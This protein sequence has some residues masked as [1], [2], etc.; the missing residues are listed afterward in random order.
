MDTKHGSLSPQ[1]LVRLRGGQLILTG[2]DNEEIADIMEV[3]PSSVRNWRRKLQEH[4]DD[5]SSLVRKKGSGRSSML[6]D[7]QKQELKQ[8]IL[9]GAVKAGYPTERWTSKIV[10]D[11]IEK[12]F[13]V[14][15]APRT[16]RDLLPTLGLS[17]QMPVVKSHKHS[18]EEVLR[19][20][21]RTWKR[22][23]KKQ[24]NSAFL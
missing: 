2:Y 18:D 10:A 12:I 22:L 24:R 8:I 6:T 17:P 5:L 23:K 19:W 20:A 7:E 16:V 13:D 3:S 9:D 14:E 11:V 4:G 21:T 1:A 15:M